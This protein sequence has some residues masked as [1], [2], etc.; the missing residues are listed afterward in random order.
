MIVSLRSADFNSMQNDINH[1][2][3]IHSV[4]HV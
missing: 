1:C 3:Y 2:A 4:L